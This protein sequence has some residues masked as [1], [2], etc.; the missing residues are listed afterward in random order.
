MIQSRQCLRYW[1][2]DAA[3]KIV[4]VQVFLQLCLEMVSN[5]IVEPEIN[6]GGKRMLEHF[7]SCFLYQFSEPISF[8][9]NLKNAKNKSNTACLTLN[10]ECFF[11]PLGPME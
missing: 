8:C 11:C 5:F 1:T 9:A 10:S 4:S 2:E 7:A 6:I 3:P